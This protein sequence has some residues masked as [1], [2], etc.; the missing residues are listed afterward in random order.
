MVV[1]GATP[2]RADGSK[3]AFGVTLPTDSPVVLRVRLASNLAVAL[4]QSGR[5][6]MSMLP[7]ASVML[8]H[9]GDG[10]GVD[11]HGWSFRDGGNMGTEHSAHASCHGL[12]YVICCESS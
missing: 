3:V 12:R 9:Y 11:V 4:Y 10:R 2:S 6:P 5:T 1:F 8:R 7:T